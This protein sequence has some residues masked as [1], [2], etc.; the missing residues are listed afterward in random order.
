LESIKTIHHAFSRH[1]AQGALEDWTPSL[2]EDQF[3]TIDLAN[4]YF[5]PTSQAWMD[6][7]IP[8]SETV[9]PDGILQA[10]VD[11]RLTHTEDN[12]VEYFERIQTAIDEYRSVCFTSQ[13]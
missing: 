4:R 1:F 10:A 7:I 3:P 6:Q 2:F 8:F 13:T 12:K 5:T 9:D 11:D